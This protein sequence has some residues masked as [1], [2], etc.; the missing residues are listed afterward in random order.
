MQIL[1]GFMKAPLENCILTRNK[2][3]SILVTFFDTRGKIITLPPHHASY[4]IVTLC[5]KA[6]TVVL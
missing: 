6:L 5:S 1:L 4:F 2:G 3:I